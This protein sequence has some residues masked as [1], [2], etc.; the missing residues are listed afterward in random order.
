MASPQKENGYTAIANE[1]LEKIVC[2]P[3]NGSE[4]RI[5]L[6]VI[7]KTYGFN[8]KEDRISLSQFSIA[9]GMKRANVC[10]TL[11]SL[12][13][14][15]LLLKTKYGYKPN[16]N[17]DEWVVVKRLP[18]VV[19]SITG[20]SQK[21]NKVV[22]KRLHTKERKTYTK[23]IASQSDAGVISE[24]ISSFEEINPSYK[25]WYGNTTQR[26]ACDRL[27]VSHGLDKIKKIL[28][29]LPRTN[30]MQFFPTITTPVQLEDKWASLS[31]AMLRKKGELQTKKK[32]LI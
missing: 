1:L 24:L 14:K 21:H 19:K 9:C 16:K 13:V 5:F 32:I 17:Y 4:M 3:V 25:K 18:P 28:V 6:F 30:G 2:A 10:E 15:R 12:V 20:S 29:L 31:S 22:V 23:D 11:K 7:R 26:A 27:L 8:K